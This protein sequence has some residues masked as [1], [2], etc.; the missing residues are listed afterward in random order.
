MKVEDILK[1]YLHISLHQGTLFVLCSRT[2]CYMLSLMNEVDPCVASA[3]VFVWDAK[4]IF[5]TIS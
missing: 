5:L 3:M 4:P 2:Q 1:S